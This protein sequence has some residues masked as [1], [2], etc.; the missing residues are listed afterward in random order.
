MDLRNVY[1]S[2]V[3]RAS[4]TDPSPLNGAYIR[5]W[6]SHDQIQVLYEQLNHHRG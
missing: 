2:F 5:Q 3:K 1:V 6:H 4:A